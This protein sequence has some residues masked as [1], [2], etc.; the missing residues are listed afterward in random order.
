MDEIKLVDIT[1]AAARTLRST[2]WIIKS[3]YFTAAGEPVFIAIRRP[4][5]FRV[6]HDHEHEMSSALS[7][8]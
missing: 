6:H 2:G 7:V 3:P 5:S 4:V 1:D 8:H